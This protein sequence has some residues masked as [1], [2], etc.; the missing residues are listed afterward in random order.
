MSK[1]A[2]D[3][4]WLETQL[5]N[6]QW[7]TSSFSSGGTNCVQV[8]FLDRGLVAMRDSKNPQNPPLLFTDAEY[9]AFINGITHG[10]LR[11]H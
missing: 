7:H 4:A 1:N 9:E 8:A 6:A 5:R 3:P 11:R 10:E 2:L